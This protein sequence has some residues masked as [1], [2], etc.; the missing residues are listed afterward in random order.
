M[1]KYS[2]IL[3]A[4]GIGSRSG[5]EIPKQNTRRGK[6]MIAYGLE[7]LAS[8]EEIAEII[9]T[10]PEGYESRTKQIADTYLSGRNCEKIVKIV[11]GG[12]SVKARVGLPRIEGLHNDHVIIHEAA[13]PLVKKDLLD[14]LLDC[15]YDSAT[16]VYSVPFT[17]LTQKD[18]FIS[19]SLNRD[20]LVNIQLPQKFPRIPLFNYH[21]SAR[22]EMKDFTDDSSLFFYYGGKVAVVQGSVENVKITDWKDFL[23]AEAVLGD[24]YE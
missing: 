3:L 23:V 12:R 5:K 22:K 13:R 20:E 15:K 6:P 21:E 16:L 7:L 14:D 4:G 24:R 19:E 10:Y 1:S 9:V 18:G 11:K 2:A 17:V 8:A